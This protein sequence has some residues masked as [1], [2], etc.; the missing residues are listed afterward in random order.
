MYSG[1]SPSRRYLLLL[2]LTVCVQLLAACGPTPFDPNTA[3]AVQYIFQTPISGDEV[4]VTL[5]LENV[6]DGV[7]VDISIPAGEGDLLGFFGNLSDESLVA[8]LSVNDPSGIVT[9]QFFDVNSV[10]MGGGG[11]NVLPERDWD[12][13]LRF[14]E[15]GS[16]SGPVEQV[17]FT[18][19]GPGLTLAHLLLASNNGWLFGVRIQG[20]SGAEGSAKIGLLEGEEPTVVGPTIRIGSPQDGDFLAETPIVVAGVVTGTD[21]VVVVNGVTTSV[22]GRRFSASVPLAEGA[23][24]ISASASN[25]LLVATDDVDVVL[26]TIP[27]V[28][29]I[30]SPLDGVVGIVSPVSVTGSVAD[31]SPIDT[32]LLN[33]QAVSVVGGSF[34]SDVSLTLGPNPLTASAVDPAGNQGATSIT[35][36]LGICLPGTQQ[37]CYDGPVGTQGVGTCLGGTQTCLVDGSDYGPCVGQVVPTTEVCNSA[38][39]DCNGSADEGLGTTTCGLGVCLHTIDNCVA[40][41]PQVCDPFEGGSSE[42]CDGLD[43]DCNG[44]VDDGIPDVVA[45]SDVGLCQPQIDSCVAGTIQTV[46]QR[47]DPVPEVCNDG[48]D[49][50]CDGAD[51]ALLDVAITSPATGTLTTSPSIDVQ[52]TVNSPVSSVTVGEVPAVITG[53]TFEALGVPLHEGVNSLT[54]TALDSSGSAAIDTVSV[55]LDTEPPTVTIDSPPDLFETSSATVTVTGMINDVVVGT[56]NAAQA[57]VSVNGLPAA[58]ANRSFSAEVAI[59]AVDGATTQLVAIGQDSAG[60]VSPP[61]TVDVVFR[62]PVEPH[63]RELSGGGQ[64]APIGSVLPDPVVVELIDGAGNPVVGETVIFKVT[65]NNGQLTAGGR[66]AASVAVVTGADGRAQAVWTL[67]TRA[68]AGNNAVE[69]SAVGFEG[70]AMFSAI[71]E[72]GPAGL[73][74]VDSGNQQT[75][76]VGKPLARPLVAVVVDDGNNRIGG[77]PVTFTVQEGGGQFASGSTEVVVTDP[78]GRAQAVLVLGPDDGIDNNTVSSTFPGNTGFPANFVASAKTA[79]D[80]AETKVSG[81]VLDN[82]DQPIEGVTLSILGTALETQS[83]SAGQFTLEPAPVGT[84]FL[85]VDGSTTSRPGVWPTLEYEVVTIPGVDNALPRPIYLLEIATENSL[86][87][88]QTEGGVLEVDELPGFSLTV[89]PGSVTFPDGGNSGFLSVTVVHADKIPMTPGFGQQPRLVVTIQPPGAEFD[90]PA[91]LTLPKVDGLAPGEV[92]ELYSFDHDLGQFVAIGTGSVGKDGTQIVSDPGVGILKAGW[93]CGGNPTTGECLHQCAECQFCNSDCV[94]EPD[95][96][97]TPTSILDVPQDCKAPACLGGF[98]AQAPDDSDLPPPDPSGNCLRSDCQDGLTVLRVDDSD[99]PPAVECMACSNGDF[100]PASN[101]TLCERNRD[102][103]EVRRCQDGNCELSPEPCVEDD[104]ST[105]CAC[106]FDDDPCTQDICDGGVTCKGIPIPGCVDADGD[107][108]PAGEDVDDMDP[109]RCRDVDGDLCDDCSSGTD[110]PA[111][112]GPDPD[113]DGICQVSDN[114]PLTPNPGQ[115]DGDG[116]GVGD[117][118]EGC[119]S[120]EAAQTISQLDAQLAAARQGLASTIDQFNDQIQVALPTVG[121]VVLITVRYSVSV[122][123]GIGCITVTASSPLLGVIVRSACGA[124]TFKS[125]IELVLGLADLL[126][127][128]DPVVQAARGVVAS[129]QSRLLQDVLGPLDVAQDLR[130]DLER[131]DCDHGEAEFE[132]LV[133]ESNNFNVHMMRIIAAL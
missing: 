93:H 46:Q 98:A 19:V 85:E 29:T 77:V 60:N 124:D 88:S 107:G 84:V 92:T 7:Q 5:T 53:L 4:P 58:V 15:A 6:A 24:T 44:A 66:T 40:G 132:R 72:A 63:I 1:R 16:Q 114:C 8:S 122:A 123:S 80:P 99:R 127:G 102:T 131:L 83:D 68:G 81:V 130:A 37:G 65:E 35:T 78:D 129:A 13:G 118:C 55:V 89:E 103:C 52:G 22:S 104:G 27:P 90:P 67:G 75:G 59:N 106:N 113:N 96:G 69:A 101:H 56:V 100:V 45:G 95:D 38:D 71:A 111:N 87:V 12:F 109:N 33:G 73:I 117:A 26:D 9:S 49:Q 94:C 32:V 34:Q 97:A 64:A 57:S 50:D 115:R 3:P 61:A 112:D 21:P 74:V 18:I 86:F 39:D 82:T 110:D 133:R 25:A 36:I 42:T 70:K 51:C 14:D 119:R 2:A 23:N 54:A 76:S 47:I 126:S 108:V 43:N 91:P 79:G 20:T 125:V 120:P 105:F 10:T 30:A 31:S 17:S 62:I 116:D 121:D 48:L 28:V 11:N 41:V 128:V